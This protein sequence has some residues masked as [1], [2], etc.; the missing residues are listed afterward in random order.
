[1]TPRLNKDPASRLISTDRL[2]I[3][4]APSTSP[5]SSFC[6]PNCKHRIASVS[7]GS[8]GVD[9]AVVD[10]AQPSENNYL[11]NSSGEGP[12]N[13]EQILTLE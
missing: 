2:Y 7:A 3:A 11:E 8:K 9:C 1:M 5:S 12:R 10:V 4:L 6:V 13:A